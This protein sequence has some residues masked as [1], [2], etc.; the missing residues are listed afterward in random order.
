MPKRRGQDYQ[1]QRRGGDL[2]GKRS[3]AA[4]RRKHLYLVLDDW[5]KGFSVHKID[6]DSFDSDSDSD[7]HRDGSAAVAG[8]LPD[9]P[10][11]RLESPGDVNMP[12]ATMGSKI[13][14]V[15][16]AR[17]GQTPILVY[18][19][20]TAGM[21][22]GPAVPAQLQCGFSTVVAAH[23]MLYAFSPPACNKQHSFYVMSCAPTGSHDPSGEG[24]SWKSLPAPP[25]PFDIYEIITSYAVHSDGRT[26]FMTTSYRDRPGLPKS[27]YSFNTKY[28]LWRWHPWVLPFRGQGYFDSELDAW[29]GLHKDGYICSCELPSDIGS[30]TPI[31]LGTM[32]LD[33]QMAED[34][35]SRKETERHLRASLTYLGRS[36]FCLLQSVMRKGSKAKYPLGDD[37]G[38]VLHLTIFGLRY[39][40]KGEL[41]TTNHKS[42]CS[43]RVTRHTDFFPPVALWV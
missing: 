36:K 7:D 30:E 16:D 41:R 6:T 22:I 25:P 28:C 5:D 37:G 31:E 14:I 24:W 39:N 17:Y 4:R 33:W 35:F 3:Q 27:T 1:D 9:S 11:L 19:V 8:H 42:S 2:A 43:Y 18:D 12:F 29:V 34:K 10:A 20:E 32:E 15:T 23:D 38:C 40:N 26:I 21:A 13:F